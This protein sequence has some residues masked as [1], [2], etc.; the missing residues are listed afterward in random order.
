MVKIQFIK[1]KII[2][3]KINAI[4]LKHNVELYN[5]L[6]KISKQREKK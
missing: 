6:Y 5:V 1:I 3:R 4:F 2:L